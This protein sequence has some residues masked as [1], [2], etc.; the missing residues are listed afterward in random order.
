[1]VI[2]G[3]SLALSAGYDWWRRHGALA[4]S[5]SIGVMRLIII[6]GR[7]E[8]CSY[9]GDNTLFT[10]QHT[11]HESSIDA[12]VNATLLRCW[13]DAKH[14]SF[15]V[16][17]TP[18]QQQVANILLLSVIP[19]LIIANI[20]HGA[21]CYC[22]YVSSARHTAWYHAATLRLSALSQVGVVHV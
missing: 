14:A 3:W 8:Y 10:R 4:K 7:R 13:R 1:M 5:M 16:N 21:G 6:G 19:R 9:I 15:A 2:T 22:H 11:S 18:G 17:I 12:I 20:C